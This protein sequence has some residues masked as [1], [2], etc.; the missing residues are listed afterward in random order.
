MAKTTVVA[1][2]PVIKRLRHGGLTQENI[3]DK[4]GLSIGAIRKAQDSKVVEFL[5]TIVPLAECFGVSP[6][7]LVDEFRS[8]AI[9]KLLQDRGYYANDKPFDALCLFGAASDFVTQRRTTIRYQGDRFHTSLSLQDANGWLTKK[10]KQHPTAVLY[11]G[12]NTRLLAY[13]PSVADGAGVVLERPHLTMS[14]GP[15]GWFDYIRFNDQLSGR[16]DPCKYEEQLGISHILSE[17]ECSRSRL[18][19]IMSCAIT[20]LSNDGFI[21]YQVRGKGV[22]SSPLRITSAVA[23]NINRY[24][25]ETHPDTNELIQ[26]DTTWQDVTKA[27]DNKYDPTLGVPHPFAAARRGLGREISPKILDFV[28]RNVLKLTGLSYSLERYHPDALFVAAVDCAKDEIV[29]MRR[30]Y[31]GEEFDEGQLEFIPA[32][33]NDPDTRAVLDDPR[34]YGGGKASLVRALELIESLSKDR[35]RNEVFQILAQAE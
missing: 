20:V 14:L 35:S 26:R 32:N 6:Y 7:A 3:Q 22:S 13:A 16:I 5:T 30:K 33:R 11:D 31:R 25:D 2:G 10:Q 23:E 27:P 9:Q 29:E 24:L 18:T 8:P 17:R 34:W 21:G 1:N 15:I 4:T 19:T 12:A 28:T